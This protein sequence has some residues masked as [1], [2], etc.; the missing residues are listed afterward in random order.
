MHTQTIINHGEWSIDD[1]NGLIEPSNDGVDDEP[2][3]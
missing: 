2:W 3:F 1:D